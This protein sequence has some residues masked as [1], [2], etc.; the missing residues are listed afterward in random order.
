MVEMEFSRCLKDLWL[1]WR[2]SCAIT[3]ITW[4]V[5]LLQGKWQFQLVQDDD[6][7]RLWHM[8]WD[9][10]VRRLCKL[11]RSMDSWRMPKYANW[12]FV[13]TASLTERSRWSLTLLFTAHREF[14]ITFT[15]MFGDLPIRYHLEVCITLCHLLMIF[16]GIVG[17][18][19]WNTKGK[20]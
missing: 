4:R 17:C 19:L 13:N 10:Q 8:D 9:T 5:I 15:R 14:L 7:T 18:T 16:L 2:V 20:S 3:S 11:L 6:S 12:S 1:C